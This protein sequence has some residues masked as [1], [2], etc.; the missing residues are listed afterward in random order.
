MSEMS[1]YTKITFPKG[2][3]RK[4]DRWKATNALNS[5]EK[6]AEGVWKGDK[7]HNKAPYSAD[8]NGVFRFD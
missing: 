2:E 7:W 1:K 5:L 8:Y 4:S 3:R 6:E